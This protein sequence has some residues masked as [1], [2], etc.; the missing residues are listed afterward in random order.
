M[1]SRWQINA[2]GA[3][4]IRMAHYAGITRSRIVKLRF[5]DT[6]SL[7]PADTN[8]CVAADYS[9]NGLYEPRSGTH[10]PWG[11]DHLKSVY[12][13]YTVI[14]VSVSLRYLGASDDSPPGIW[15][16]AIVD[17]TGE[18]TGQGVEHVLQN[19]QTKGW[20]A[21]PNTGDPYERSSSQ[22]ISTYVNQNTFFGRNVSTEDNFSGTG[23]SNPTTQSYVE[24]FA[25]N[26]EDSSDPPSLRLMITLVYTARFYEPD[27]S[28]VHDT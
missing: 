24:V 28:A 13:R 6:F 17:S 20:R 23:S 12:S 16:V 19:P 14:G 11:F 27:L 4:A 22:M 8:V 15:G 3:G 2:P 25:G 18:Y 1:Q 26:Q 7:D 5:C 9:L 10:Q 21:Y